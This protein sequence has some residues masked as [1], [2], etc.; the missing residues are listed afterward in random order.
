MTS[1]IEHQAKLY[2]ETLMM[3]P[4]HYEAYLKSIT[5]QQVIFGEWLVTY[6]I[7]WENN[8]QCQTFYAGFRLLPANKF[9]RIEQLNKLTS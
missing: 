7:T 8:W 6:Y 9:I 5:N 2:V 3:P 4:S 1:L